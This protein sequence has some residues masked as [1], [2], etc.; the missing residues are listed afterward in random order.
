MTI[1]F[2]SGDPLNRSGFNEATQEFVNGPKNAIAGGIGTDDEDNDSLVFPADLQTQEFYPEAIMFGIYERAGYNFNKAADKISGTAAELKEKWEAIGKLDKQIASSK[3]YTATMVS[4]GRTTKGEIAEQR[5][6]TKD[7][8]DQRET[9]AKALTPGAVVGTGVQ[10][11]KDEVSTQQDA[12]N[13]QI[14]NPQ[15]RLR[16]NIYLQMPESVIFNEQVDWQSTDLGLVGAF[17]DGQLGNSS[18]LA[19]GILGNAGKVLCGAAGA[20]ASLIPGIGTT[21]ATVVGTVL[22]GATGISGGIESAFN[23]KANPYKEQTFQGVPFRPFEFNFTFRPRNQ[24]EVK[25][26]K[27]I[28]TEFRAYSKPGFNTTAESGVF[29]YPHEFRIEFLKLNQTGDD[30]IS[31]DNLPMVKYCILK[32]VATNFTPQGWRTL[33]DGAPTDITLTLSFEETEIITREDVFG[34][35]AVGD[36]AKSKGRF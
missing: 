35:T 11:F 13:E 28:I 3:E 16:R 22:G 33:P 14:K 26:A 23:I 19:A 12:Y 27:D 31:N 10:A 18:T 8:Q 4:K 29:A 5:A 32:T 6:R 36:F 21:A 17:K 2:V 25:I 15:K 9:A 20:M 34:K 1:K 7:L 24:K 30:W